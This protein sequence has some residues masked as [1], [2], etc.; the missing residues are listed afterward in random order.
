MIAKAKM[1][2][3]AGTE[4]R[5]WVADIVK[6]PAEQRTKRDWGRLGVHHAQAAL[7]RVTHYIPREQREA[8]LRSLIAAAAYER[9]RLSGSRLAWYYRALH[10]TYD[11]ALAVEESERGWLGPRI[12]A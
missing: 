1:A 10:T 7:A 5:V 8:Y 12:V 9:D 11:L 3:F 2:P 4:L 6:T